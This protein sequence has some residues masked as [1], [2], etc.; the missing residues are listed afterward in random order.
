[1]TNF[2]TLQND[3][4]KIIAVVINNTRY[5]PEMLMLQMT[6]V[7]MQS[8]N[9]TVKLWKEAA[10]ACYAE[11]AELREQVE[12]Y[13]A[14]IAVADETIDALT[15]ALAA[16]QE[17][18]RDAEAALAVLIDDMFKRGD[19]AEYIGL[20]IRAARDVVLLNTEASRRVLSERLQAF[21]AYRACEGVR[22]KAVSTS[23]GN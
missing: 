20:I 7:N 22:V 1:M 21:D 8:H 17:D 11:A 18:T 6:A 19:R 9:E 13:A 23:D 16:Q 3:T 12:K 5:S 4:G 14:R 2:S 10:E 15:T